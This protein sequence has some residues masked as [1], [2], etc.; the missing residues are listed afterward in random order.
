MVGQDLCQEKKK[1]ETNL[2]GE[3]PY[4]K[5]KEGLN[6]EEMMMTARSNQSLNNKRGQK[7]EQHEY[8][9]R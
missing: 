1:G 8:E 3:L 6:T 2:F 4:K 5:K 9:K 7:Y